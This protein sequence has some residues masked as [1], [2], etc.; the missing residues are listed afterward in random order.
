[1]SAIDRTFGAQ[2]TGRDPNAVDERTLMVLRVTEKNPSE[3]ARAAV[4]S[5]GYVDLQ[6]NSITYE[7]PGITRF[8]YTDDV[9]SLGD[10]WSAGVP[11]PRGRYRDLLRRGSKVEVFLSNPKVNGGQYTRKLVGRIRQRNLTIDGGGSVINVSGSDLGYHLQSNPA[12]WFNLRWTDW[13]GLMRAVLDPS[14]EITDVR[15]GN[16]IN[17]RLNNGRQEKQLQLQPT[18]LLSPFARI[19]ISPGQTAADLLTTY[20]RR[21]G[22]LLTM[23]ADGVLQT[24]TP[25]YTA[26]PLYKVRLYDWPYPETVETNVER[27]QLSESADTIYTHTTCVG[28]SVYTP[29]GYAQAVATEG[30]A[31]PLGQPQTATPVTGGNVHAG[32][33]PRTA[34]HANAL[35]YVNRKTFCDPER[36]DPASAKL[37][38]EWTYQR[39]VFDAWSLTVTVRGHHNQ[40][41]WWQ[42]DTM[43]DV[44]IDVPALRI[45]SA[46]VPGALYVSRVVYGATE[47]G[48]TTEV[49]LRLP[50]LLG[51]VPV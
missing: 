38:A 49:T 25:N 26:T 27:L 41:T 39:G 7:V 13:K 16:D 23:G 44:D 40:G 31:A 8:S 50:N 11:D 19:E 6:P 37:R 5:I 47:A 4:A 42:A 45:P 9:L 24:F 36:M 17:Q 18:L 28:Q 3:A 43:V 30:Q 35:P 12:V 10:A 33:W 21:R 14:W 22:L 1:M 2:L 48:E 46:T 34:V 32:Q 51:E 29:Q 20:A 15:L